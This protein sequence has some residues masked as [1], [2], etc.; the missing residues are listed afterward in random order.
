[1]SDKKNNSCD[2]VSGLIIEY[3]DGELDKETAAMAERH[4]CECADCRK[5]YNDMVAV[6]RAASDSAYDVPAGLHCRV[7]DSV[8]SSKHLSRRG[9]MR[10]ISAFAGIGAAA[11]ICVSVGITAILSH[12]GKANDATLA[13]RGFDED[14]YS[15]IEN[16]DTESAVMLF[17]FARSAGDKSF[18]YTAD[19]ADDTDTKAQ[20][21]K[22]TTGE[23]GVSGSTQEENIADTTETVS[24]VTAETGAASNDTSATTVGTGD[25]YDDTDSDEPA[26]DS[27]LADGSSSYISAPASKSENLFGHW[28]LTA[29]SGAIISLS[30]AP[31]MTFYL[32]DTYGNVTSG[33]Y[34]IDDGNITFT[35]ASSTA[36]YRYVYTGDVIGFTPIDGAALIR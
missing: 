30:L 25:G 14:G 13:T 6:C 27:S 3:I 19:C 22:S 2:I 35:Y 26:S 21:D 33:D 9:K 36:R 29:E 5:L 17:N 28:E 32:T 4:I 18:M 31:D 10:R 15:V 1:M 20:S 11:M 8:K 16:A 34:L 24:T 12:I 23:D 7:M